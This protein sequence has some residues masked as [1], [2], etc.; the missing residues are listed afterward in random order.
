MSPSLETCLYCGEILHVD[1]G[2]T[3]YY[4]FKNTHLKTA[5]FFICED[6]I[7]KENETILNDNNYGYY[8]EYNKDSETHRLNKKDL[9]REWGEMAIFKL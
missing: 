4:L 1:C 8:I 3:V 7:E 6:C 5:E 2:F 9:K